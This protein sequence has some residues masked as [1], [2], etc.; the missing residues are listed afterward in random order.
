MLDLQ[1]A[2]G[3]QAVVQLL[4]AGAHGSPPPVVPSQRSHL[5]NRALS[6]MLVAQRAPNDEHSSGAT[7]YPAGDATSYPADSSGPRSSG[8]RSSGAG[9][10]GG[11]TEQD[12]LAML[13][14]P[15]VIVPVGGGAG[16]VAAPKPVPPGHAGGVD[17]NGRRRLV[18]V[19]HAVP[20]GRVRK[21]YRE[22]PSSVFR[23][24]SVNFHNEMWRQ[25]RTDDQP[26]E[27]PVAFAAGRL[28]AVHPRYRG[29]ATPIPGSYSGLDDAT[30]VAALAQTALDRTAPKP[31]RPMMNAVAPGSGVPGFGGTP[32]YVPGPQGS[33]RQTA[34]PASTVDILAAMKADPNSVKRSPDSDFHDQMYRL[35]QGKGSTTPTAFRVGNQILVSPGHPIKGVETLAI[36]GRGASPGAPGAPVAGGAA[37]TPTAPS[38]SGGRRV[39]GDVNVTK[40]KPGVKGELMVENETTDGGTTTKKGKGATASVGGG[41]VASVGGQSVVT[42]TK[43][44]TGTTT[45][46]QANLTLKPD[47]GFVLGSE[48][49]TET[50][51]GRNEAGD[52]IKTGGTTTNKGVG[53]SDKGLTGQAGATRETGGG[54][55]VGA[56]GSATMDGKG[57]I[58]GEGSLKFESKGGTSLTPSISGGVSVQA[59][60]P[61]PA[62]GGGFEVTYTITTSSGAGLGASKQFG[63]GPSVGIQ[64]GTTSGTLD[65]GTRH[66]DDIKNAQ[67][68]RD[69]AAAVIA[70]EQFL[71]HPPPNTVEGALLIPIGEERG[72]GDMTGSSYGG[73]VAFEGASL[74]YGKSESTIHQFRVRHTR[75]KVVQVTGSVVGTKGSELSGSGIITLGRG[76]SNTR[77]FEVV[78]EID[79]NTKPGRDSFELYARTGM[80]PFAAKFVSMTSSGSEE[81]HDS[82]SIPLLGTAKWT[83]TTWEIIREDASGRHAQFGGKQSRDQDPSWAGKHIFGQDTIHSN[84]QITSKLDTDKEGNR[85]ES[86]EAQITVSGTTGDE[87]R[88]ELGQIWSGA[89]HAGTTKASGEWT[90]SAQVSQEVVRDLEKV[91]KEMRLAPTKE[92]KMRVYSALVKEH[93]IR[94]VGAQAG[95]GGD[96]LAW[97][98]ELKGDKNFPGPSGRAA[99]DTKRATLRGQLKD[100]AAAKTVVG[101]AQKT[102]DLLKARRI[103]VADRERYTD[104]PDGLRDQQ[105]KLIDKHITDFEFIRHQGLRAALKAEAG[106]SKPDAAKPGAGTPDAA[107][108]GGYK[109]NNEAAESA[110]MLKLRTAIDQKETA[111]SALDP[112]ISRAINAVTQA[113]PRVVNVAPVYAG[114]V[115]AHKASYNE[116][117]SMG[118][119]MNERQSAMAPKIDTLRQKLLESLFAVDRKAAAE[120]LLAQLTDRL[121]LLETLH[122]HVVGAAEAIKPITT[123]LG[124]K[125]YPKFWGSIKGDEPPWNDPFGS[126]ED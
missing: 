74:G 67:A 86:Y 71:L 73:S 110:D 88:K 8:P 33:N 112:R 29:G 36:P 75:D 58:S 44:D 32:G 6:S 26:D 22:D 38:G 16:Q 34:V 31:G 39:K 18:V 12:D 123:A 79:L 46:K 122:I 63:G 13:P 28:I 68:F 59:S 25:M 52:P 62:E 87:T 43:G 117:W 82:V 55:K 21:Q 66:F 49:S 125:G 119:S 30:A 11:N 42:E 113:S 92:D 105:L 116:H 93:G 99:L 72:S 124:M 3:N 1:Q 89:R 50:F 65:T 96:P 97:S 118:I 69:T 15:K 45:K 9:P 56:Q 77:G 37:A 85:E 108:A 51:K 57:N 114:W 80:P 40:G 104:L 17:P 101:E 90:L 23:S 54:H 47:G 48:K 53:L 91:N 76:S 78:W 102:I 120:A 126:A 95:L 10:A 106:A 84:S 24:P 70:G 20:E 41:N 4:A 107:G 109:G 94:M 115:L 5:G 2:Y 103:A 64:M 19:P 83:G 14:D 35:D 81:D 61:T 100:A 7:S 60:D 111:I 98:V 121:A 27:P